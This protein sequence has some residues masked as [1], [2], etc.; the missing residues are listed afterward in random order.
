MKTGW[1]ILGAANMW[2]FITE[3][4]LR[5]QLSK[6]RKADSLEDIVRH[7]EQ[8]PQLD[9]NNTHA[10]TGHYRQGHPVLGTETGKALE[11]TMVQVDNLIETDNDNIESNILGQSCRDVKKRK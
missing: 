3:Q 11:K 9:E 10:E 5:D 7:F 4:Y 6:D 1:L 8:K 2:I